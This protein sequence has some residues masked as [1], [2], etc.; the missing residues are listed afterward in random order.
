MWLFLFFLE[1]YMFFSLSQLYWNLLMMVPVWVNVYLLFWVLSKPFQMG[2]SG[3]TSPGDFLELFYWL[4]LSMHFY[5]SSFLEF[6]GVA[7][8]G[9]AKFLFSYPCLIFLEIFLI[10]EN[11]QWFFCPFDCNVWELVVAVLWMILLT[12]LC[13]CF[14]VKE[15]SILSSQDTDENILKA[16]SS[17]LVSASFKLLISVYV[18]LQLP[19]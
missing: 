3:S 18:A 5:C 1:V 10:F 9:L 6:L 7:P 16:S 4:F 13:F 11:C 19:L 8:L 12:V 15:S 17:C 14:A 2:D